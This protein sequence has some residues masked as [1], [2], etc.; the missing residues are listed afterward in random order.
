MSNM[1]KSDDVHIHILSDFI[2]AQNQDIL[3][4]ITECGH[5]HIYI[6]DNVACFRNLKTSV[7]SIYTWYRLML[8]E[9]VD[10][11]IEK[12]LYLDCDV[13]VNRDLDELFSMNM[14]G[15]AIAGCLDIQSYNPTTFSRIG[16]SSDS[17]YI[18]AG[19]LLM[20]LSKWRKEKI[21][22]TVI[23]FA[24]ENEERILYPDQDAIN[25]VCRNEKI[26][27]P[28]R[29]GVIVPYFRNMDF[30]EEHMDEMDN[31]MAS[32][33][34]VHYAGYAPW[35]YCKNKSLHSGLWWMHYKSLHNFPEVRKNYYV[36]FVKYCIRYILSTA[37]LIKPENKFYL[38]NQYYY[39]P[40]VTAKSVMNLTQKLGHTISKN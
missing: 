31:L 32:P 26:I 19:V 17:R 34:I 39:H 20:N 40:K 15:Y 11:N 8:P 28:C 12:I 22:D 36:S 33:C 23:N 37:H 7:W 35:I 29:Y 14:E 6:C 24:L 21:S 4:R 27:L 3:N 2:S 9:I 1:K 10:I 25:Y 18:C 13:V 38:K 5:L 30:I 16:Y